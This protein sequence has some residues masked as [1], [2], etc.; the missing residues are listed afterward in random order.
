MFRRTHALM[1][2]GVVALAANVLVQASPALA[3]TGKIGFEGTAY[4]TSVNVANVVKSGRSALSSLGCTDQVGVIHTNTAAS[5]TAPE[6]L[7][8]T[9]DTSAASETT[10]TGVASTS[11]TTVQ[12]ATLL[13]GLVSATT[14]ESVATTSRDNSTKKF[15]NSAAGTEFLG[16]T[17][18]GVPVSG[19]PAPNTKL[20][21]PGVGYVILNQQTGHI[22]GS[23]ASLTV[24][25]IH[26]VVTLSTPLAPVGTNIVVSFANSALG[27]AFN[28]LLTG[29]AYGAEANVLSGILILGEL[30]PQPLG[31][32]GTDGQT[33]TNGGAIV[34]VPALALTGTVVDTAEGTQ[35]HKVTSAEVT[36]TIQGVNLLSGLVTATAVKADVTANGNPPTLAD[37]STFLGL[38][39]NG[40]PFSGTP[41][42]NTKI[43][44]AGLGTLWLHRV[45]TTSN[46]IHVIMIQLI[47]TVPSNPLGLAPGTRVNVASAKVGVN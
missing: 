4:G 28:G 44:L 27:G 13:G 34:S 5:V 21:L 46:T 45:F 14:L 11:M 22:G 38:S 7:T 18:A 16:L 26:V 32:F 15:S 35:T 2:A 43:P 47:V 10:S 42:P 41:P 30:F 6:L 31:C 20:A 24:I 12:G 3:K 25:A 33:R 17:V 1:L 23:K 19:T 40:T 29:L 37:N 8:G 36:S 9:I 39:I